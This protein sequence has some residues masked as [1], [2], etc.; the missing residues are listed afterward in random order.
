M[1]YHQVLLP[2]YTK[3]GCKKF[4]TK[5]NRHFLDE[6]DLEELSNWEPIEFQHPIE[7]IEMT[8]YSH[9]KLSKPST[10]VI[11][12]T[13]SSLVRLVGLDLAPVYIYNK[14]T[15]DFIAT[16]RLKRSRE[17]IFEDILDGHEQSL[18]FGDDSSMV[19]L[20]PNMTYKLETTID[21]KYRT[22]YSPGYY[23]FRKIEYGAGELNPFDLT[24]ASPMRCAPSFLSAIWLNK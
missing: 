11:D 13:V 18:S 9:L 16:F 15:E 17:V 7:K 4:E 21:M 2:G 22:L 1:A 20:E 3:L 10:M 6:D 23:L 8:E 12:F 19:L 14:P 5:Y 24:D